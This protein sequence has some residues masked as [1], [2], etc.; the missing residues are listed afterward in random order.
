MQLLTSIQK[1]LKFNS[2]P[3]KAKVL[4]SFFKTG[5]GEYGEGDKFLGITVPILRQLAKKYVLL[6]IK[7]STTLLKSP[8]HEA[9]LLALL[10]QVYQ[11]KKYTDKQKSIYT[12][13]IS[14]TKFINNWDLVDLSAP[15]IMGHYLMDKSPEL[16][17]NFANS[18]NLWKRRIAIVSQ[19]LPIRSNKFDVALALA[20]LLLHD[21]HDLIHKA[22]GWV[23]RE[24]GKRDRR[25]EEAFI[26]QFHKTIP[27]TTLRYAIEHFDD[28]KRQYYLKK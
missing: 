8:Y 15:Y 9:R 17:F 28:E 7:D 21:Q 5:P 4:V 22:V 27:R 23:L 6:T 14:S 2:N 3:K 20:E 11:Y 19:L 12:H 25:K 10:I 1:D 18:N 26:K 24:I 16:L 13:Y